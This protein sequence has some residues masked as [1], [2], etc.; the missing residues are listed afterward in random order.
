MKKELNTN[1][2]NERTNASDRFADKDVWVTT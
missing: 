1:N 2:E